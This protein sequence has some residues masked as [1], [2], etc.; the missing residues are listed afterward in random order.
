MLLLT[1]M[2]GTHQSPSGLSAP[3]GFMKFAVYLGRPATSFT[4][5]WRAKPCFPY[6]SLRIQGKSTVGNRLQGMLLD[7]SSGHQAGFAR[8]GRGA[9]LSARGQERDL[10]G[11]SAPQVV[12]EYPIQWPAKSPFCASSCAKYGVR[13]IGEGD[14]FQRSLSAVRRSPLA[15][16]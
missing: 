12:S 5:A 2:F 1:C 3:V 16:E 7:A 14:S 8:L 11:L 15:V 10:Q 6:C 4:L 9:D 13:T